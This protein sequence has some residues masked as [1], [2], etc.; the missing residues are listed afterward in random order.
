ME[1]VYVKSALKATS[2]ASP[3]KINELCFICHYHH[4]Y[5]YRNSVTITAT[6]IADAVQ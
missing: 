1:G 6:K 3:T 2:T 5:H 4:R